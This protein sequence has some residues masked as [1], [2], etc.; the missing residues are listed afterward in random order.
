M[1][2]LKIFS[3]KDKLL[4]ELLVFLV[5]SVMT[6]LSIHFFLISFNNGRASNDL[7]IK[8]VKVVGP[9]QWHSG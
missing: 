7:V 4:K 2:Y 1:F 6:V 3:I 9:A 5:H 8:K